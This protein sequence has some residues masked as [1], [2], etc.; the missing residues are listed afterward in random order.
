MSVEGYAID[1]P[2]TR[3]TRPLRRGLGSVVCILLTLGV[4]GCSADDPPS[5]QH[6]SLS[7][8]KQ[9]MRMLR[10]QLDNLESQGVLV[11]SFGLNAGQ[12]GIQLDPLTADGSEQIIRAL[13]GSDGVNI[14]RDG[15]VA[16]PY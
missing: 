10:G 14:T 7:V 11:D 13:I 5:R 2:G 16:T 9:E 6:P 8:L 12:L 4:S 3:D 15:E 1:G